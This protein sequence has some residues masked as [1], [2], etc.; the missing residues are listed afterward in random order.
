MAVY[1][2]GRCHRCGKDETGYCDGTPCVCKECSQKEKDKKEK[3]RQTEIRHHLGALEDLDLPFRVQRLE[4]IIF[5][6]FGK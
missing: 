4:R 3:E 6:K 5:E 1:L 2:L